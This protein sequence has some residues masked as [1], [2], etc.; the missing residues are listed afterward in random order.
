M[1]INH[2]EITIVTHCPICHRANFVEV[3]EADYWDW[4]DGALAQDVFPY[5][6]TDERGMLINGICS[7]CWNNVLMAR[8]PEQGN[9]DP[10][11]YKFGRAC[12]EEEEDPATYEFEPGRVYWDEMAA[13]P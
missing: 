1:K 11:T 13:N 3:N 12:W 2:K 6:S 7:T 10:E 4:R 5:L 8:W 9:E